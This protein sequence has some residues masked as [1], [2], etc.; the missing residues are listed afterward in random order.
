MVG[1][2][3]R[4][5]NRGFSTLYMVCYVQANSLFDLQD[6][7][8]MPTQQAPHAGTTAY[9]RRRAQQRN[10]RRR[11]VVGPRLGCA[12]FLLLVV[13]HFDARLGR[14]RRSL[15]TTSPVR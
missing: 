7:E 1:W 2:V 14:V 4:W 15:T 3:V 6:R 8:L 13:G 9:S 12:V 10:I 5:F 11:T